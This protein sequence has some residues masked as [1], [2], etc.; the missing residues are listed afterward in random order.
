MPFLEMLMKWKIICV[1]PG[2]TPKFDGLSLAHATPFKVH[3]NW[4][5]K[6]HQQTTKQTRGHSNSACPILQCKRKWGKRELLCVPH[7][8]DRSKIYLVSFTKFHENWAS[9]FTIILL[10]NRAKNILSRGQKITHATSIN[11]LNTQHH[12][13]YCELLWH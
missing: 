11:F 7:D 13:D 8:S 1:T 4:A 12:P 9:S 2:S 5:R 6:T 3:E 10:T